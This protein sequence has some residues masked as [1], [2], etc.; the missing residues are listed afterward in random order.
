MPIDSVDNMNIDSPI[1][2]EVCNWYD[3][4]CVLDI[5]NTI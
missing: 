4:P 5:L 1:P 3:G 2:K